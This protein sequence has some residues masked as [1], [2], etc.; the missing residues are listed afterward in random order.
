MMTVRLERSDPEAM[1]SVDAAWL[2]MDRPTNLMTIAAVLIF[3]KQLDHH[4]LKETLRTR[5]LRFP[6]FRQR[7]VKKDGSTFCWET[8]PYFDLDSH[9]RRIALPGAADRAELQELVSDLVCTPFDCTKP[10]WHFD[11]VDDYQ[12]GSAL[13]ARIHHCYG[14]GVAITRVLLS[15][16]DATPDGARIDKDGEPAPDELRKAGFLQQI[17]EPVGDLIGDVLEYVAWLLQEETRLIRHPAVAI[18]YARASLGIS[19]EL[20]KLVLLPDDPITCF[21]GRLGV[22][23][24]VAWTEPLPFDEVKAVSRALGCTVNDVALTCVTGALRSYLVDKGEEVD[25]LVIKV[26]VPVN[27]RPPG[28]SKDLGN[29]FG[30]VFLELPLYIANPLERLYT[31]KRNMQALKASKQAAA[32]HYLLAALGAAPESVERQAID[33]F[34]RKATAVISNVPGP[35]HTLYL[36]GARIEEIMFWVPQSGSIGMG[37]SILSYDGRMQF[38][39]ITDKRRVSDPERIVE[40]FA[41]EFEDLVLLTLMSPWGL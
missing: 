30:L 35:Q 41:R 21:K 8:D 23:K 25:G 1:A 34:S 4:R 2:R 20:A 32:T 37:I 19:A 28:E 17:Y 33:L 24:R 29:R 36:A 10:L 11:L 6:R 14:D 31:V 26:V 39:L 15:M 38:G 9:W 16:T 40:C 18:D 5:F 12:G 27:L 3:R 22:R 7:P 13:I